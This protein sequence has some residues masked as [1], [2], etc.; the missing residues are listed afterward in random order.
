MN[1]EYSVIDM[2]LDPDN[3]SPI[4]CVNDN[5]MEVLFDQIAVIP[6]KEKLVNTQKDAKLKVAE[7]KQSVLN[8]H[9]QNLAALKEKLALYKSSLTDEEVSKIIEEEF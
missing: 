9:K 2:L 4:S 6:L 7:Y 8:E 3:E 1:Q 5:G